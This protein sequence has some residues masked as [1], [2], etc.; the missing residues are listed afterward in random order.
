[1]ARSGRAG[2]IITLGV[3]FYSNGTLFDPFEIEDVQIFNDAILSSPLIAELTPVRVSVGFYQIQ[4]EPLE[5]IALGTYY[6]E[7]TWTAEEF[8]A[9]N[10]QRY[11]FEILEPSEAEPIPEPEAIGVVVCLRPRPEWVHRMG[12]RV[13]EDVGNGMGV[14]LSWQEAIPGEDDKQVHY[15]IY[16]ATKRVGVFEDQFL[17]K[18]VTT[19]VEAIINITPGN[20]H[21]FAVRATEFDPA[22]FNI[23]ELT[24]IGDG[25]GRYPDITTLTTSIDAYGEVVVGV[26][27]NENFPSAG[28]LLIGTEIL[29]YTSLGTN[30]FNVPTNGRGNVGTAFASHDVGDE[31]RLWRGVEE[32][33]SVIHS[34]TAAW[35]QNHDIPGSG[36][37]YNPDPAVQGEFN[38]AEDGYR[39]NAEDIVTTDLSASDANTAN[40][41]TFDF[42]G[43]HRPS[44]Q[45][46]FSGQCVGSYVGGEFNGSRGFNFQDRILSQ[47]DVMLQVTGEPVILLRRRQTGRRCRCGASDLR[48]EHPRQRCPYCFG[49]GFD[50]GYE[51][52][53]NTRAISELFVNTAGRI[54]IRTNPFVDD[55]K[56]E[57]SQGLVQPSELTAWT[58]VFPTIKDRDIIVRFNENGTE[59]FRYEI[60]DV[61][62][63]RLV[64]GQSGRQEFRMRR[65]DKTDVV[66]QYPANDPGLF[67]T[68]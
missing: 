24:Q 41:S 11:S 53:F 26:E 40:F 49:T 67:V 19:N 15:N 25:V 20:L 46:T 27:S 63:N 56:I 1:M 5:T 65:M 66:Y 31:V 45:E 48:R 57:Q 28:F 22:Q 2:S 32:G 44:I 9:S 33:N 68:I 62:R 42:C 35:M 14:R 10:T 13:L 43:Y 52:F 38:V 17:P 64:F 7:W 8:M 4:F 55:L 23:A 54:M 3:K 50:G 12:L 34:Y 39:E 30:T 21:Y 37:A 16:H 6:D 51:R 47:L 58:I 59:E 61:T 29:R 36:Y 18:A 60:L